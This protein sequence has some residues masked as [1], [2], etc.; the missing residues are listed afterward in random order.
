VNTASVAVTDLVVC[1]MSLTKS[2]TES[3]SPVKSVPVT[4]IYHS[5][6]DSSKLVTVVSITG[7]FDVQVNEAFDLGSQTASSEV[8]RKTIIISS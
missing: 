6:R 3:L 5:L 8:L 7:I 1:L 2:S 4:T